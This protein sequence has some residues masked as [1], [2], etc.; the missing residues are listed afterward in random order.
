MMAA[1]Y[2][3]I[4]CSKQITW[5][6]GRTRCHRGGI[7]CET[8]CPSSFLRSPATTAIVLY[9]MRVARAASMQPLLHVIGVIVRAIGE[10]GASHVSV[11]VG[12]IGV[13]SSIVCMTTGAGLEANTDAVGAP[14]GDLSMADISTRVPATLLVACG[15][16]LLSAAQQPEGNDDGACDAMSCVEALNDLISMLHAL[17]S[18]ASASSSSKGGGVSTRWLPRESDASAAL[19]TLVSNSMPFL[20]SLDDDEQG[21]Q[22]ETMGGSMAAPLLALLESVDSAVATER[23]YDRGSPDRQ[24]PPPSRYGHGYGAGTGSWS[25]SQPTDS[26]TDKMQQLA[27]AACASHKEASDA[28][29]LMDEFAAL[30]D[31]VRGELRCRL[32][33]LD[34]A[35]TQLAARDAAAAA[36]AERLVVS[37][38]LCA[39]LRARCDELERANR[40]L[41]RGG[42]CAVSGG[43]GGGGGWA[44]GTIGQQLTG[45]GRAFGG[46]HG[47][48]MDALTSPPVGAPP[49]V[50]VSMASAAEDVVSA[51]LRQHPL[52]GAGARGAMN[53]SHVSAN[54]NSSTL[55]TSC[56]MDDTELAR[57]LGASLRRTFLRLARSR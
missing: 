5:C 45:Q 34:D 33:E 57:Q 17:V 52:S 18:S 56:V 47:R 13:L 10:H 28:V 39:T 23:G 36:L 8:Y 44:G 49:A 7:L 15:D 14:R 43:G 32:R 51:A 40:R 27:Q 25:R 42:N 12:S 3:A 48:P 29:A 11:D 54:A 9:D 22:T 21:A 26:E 55:S 37:E 24:Q 30:N 20:S 31:R 6:V 41:R 1:A 2:F 38:L 46:G 53:T 19:R 50:F 35:R 4:A 16:R